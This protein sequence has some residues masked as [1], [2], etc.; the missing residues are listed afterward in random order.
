MN[1]KQK[2]QLTIAGVTALSLLLI[3]ALVYIFIQNDKIAEQEQKQAESEKATAELLQISKEELI[4][5]YTEYARQYDELQQSISNDSLRMQ[6]EIERQRTR[7]LLQEL[8]RVKSSD[9]AEITRLKKELATVRQVLE[10]YIKQI[11]ELNIENEQL[12]EEISVISKQHDAAQQKITTL[13]QQTEELSEKVDIASQLDAFGITMQMTNA[14][15][16]EV[17][18]IKKAKFFKIFFNIAKNVTTETGNKTIYVRILKPDEEL[19]TKDAANLFSYED[20]EIG[21]SIKKYIEFDGNET[22]VSVFWPIEETLS[23]GTY[24]VQ[25]FVDGNMIGESSFTFK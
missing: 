9:A 13:S 15:E 14:K 20:R 23:A 10:S 22:S 19:L 2:K 8:E 11:D 4:N 3:S 21:Y 25:L 7:D 1:D 18:R 5:E 12:K 17:S 6:L 24:R 16:K